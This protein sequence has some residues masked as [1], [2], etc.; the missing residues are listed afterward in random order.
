MLSFKRYL[1]L[2]FSIFLVNCHTTSSQTLWEGNMLRECGTGNTQEI[3]KQKAVSSLLDRLLPKQIYISKT[4]KS[5]IV[6]RTSYHDSNLE[7][8]TKGSEE[9]LSQANIISAGIIDILY[10]SPKCETEDGS[11]KCCV[12]VS[13]EEAEKYKKLA[14]RVYSKD[15]IKLAYP[16][17]EN[18]TETQ[19]HKWVVSAI[20]R[21]LAISSSELRE[22]LKQYLKDIDYDEE[23]PLEIAGKTYNILSVEVEDIQEAIDKVLRDSWHNLKWHTKVPL[24]TLNIDLSQMLIT[25]LKLPNTDTVKRLIK[26]CINGNHLK[27]I[28]LTTSQEHSITLVTNK[29]CTKRIVYWQA[30]TLSKD[31]ELKELITS[32]TE[33]VVL[34]KFPKTKPNI[35][36]IVELKV[37]NENM[38]KAIENLF[39]YINIRI[40]NSKL[41]VKPS[42][43]KT[44]SSWKAQLKVSVEDAFRCASSKCIQL[45]VKDRRNDTIWNGTIHVKE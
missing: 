21:H 17:Y 9:L 44:N 34:N 31:P 23:E 27:A 39:S 24:K 38:A 14:A 4:L 26:S 16:S 35:A 25:V 30:S 13:R 3:A 1:Y 40:A 12:E 6:K 7:L 28:I 42:F 19:K 43:S 8:K 29:P 45:S 18:A 33:Y 15:K 32:I 20:L 36:Y 5:K 41:L 22:K 2:L 10:S 37:A 11:V